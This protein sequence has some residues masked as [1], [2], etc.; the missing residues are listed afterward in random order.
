M[1]LVV[2][3]LTGD[4]SDVFD[5]ILSLNPG[6]TQNLTTILQMLREHYCGSLTFREQRNAIENLCQR[7]QE[8]A[9]DFL[10]RVG[11]SMSNLGKDWKDELME[12]ELRSLQYE[13]SL[14]GVKEE[15]RHVLDSKIAKNEGKLTPQQM[16]E[17]V[18]KYETY[19]ARNKRLEGKGT[20][21]PANQQRATGHT[22]G[23]KP[24]FHKTTAFAT[25]IV[26]SEDD[27]HRHQESSPQGDID[28]LG[29]E[30]SQEDDEGLFIPSYLEEAL[31]DDP[32]LQVKM[33]H[34]M[35]AQEMETRRCF[36]CN[37]PDHLQRDHWKYEEKMG[38]A[39]TAE[40]TPLKQVSSRVGEAKAPSARLNNI[41]SK[42]SK[43][44][45]APYL[46]PD[47]FYRFI[48]PKNQDKALIDDELTTCL[49]DNGA[50]LNFITLAYAQ[51][52][53]MDIM[54]L[55]YLAWE[56]GGP[57]PPIRGIGSIP[58]EPVGF[59]MVNVKVPCV[60]GYDE[61]QVTIVMDDPDMSECPVYHV[62]E[63]IKESEISKLA[64]PWA[65]S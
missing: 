1:P 59:V 25:M 34:A 52:Q 11:T 9:I 60:Q 31:P 49:L 16:Y 33:A 32:T 19:V 40:G 30:S 41:S 6:N 50:Q 42:P 36:T 5:W 21:S 26:E 55:D 57:I 37:K 64:V 24:R 18:K 47:A 51:E 62:M 28:S 7:P 63:V 13:V 65:S 43:V 23:Y 39:P 29:A 35:R 4:A 8:A 53:G 44:K 45:R 22:S 46:N 20:S 3:S 56:I 61:D 10:I 58:V 14:N 38:L 17:A 27:A 48:G 15:I 12:K 2:S 54:S